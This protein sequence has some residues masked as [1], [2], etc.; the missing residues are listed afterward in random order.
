[1][2]FIYINIFNSL[3][4]FIEHLQATLDKVSINSHASHVFECIRIK[5]NYV[6]R[7]KWS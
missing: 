7:N 4:S 1:M 3:A 5:V 6:C 2:Y